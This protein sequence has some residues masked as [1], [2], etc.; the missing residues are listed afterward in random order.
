MNLHSY[1]QSG[2]VEAYAIGLITPA[3]K[4]EFEQLLNVYPEL[5]WEL[6]RVSHRIESVARKGAV[7]PPPGA[8]QKIAEAIEGLPVLR[9]TTQQK[10]TP[11]IGNGDRT[12]G[13]IEASVTSDHISV[14]KLMKPAFIIIFILSKIFL[15][16]LIFYMVKFYRA[17]SELQDVKHQIDL[18]KRPAGTNR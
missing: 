11:L 14:H 8:R 17:Q 5:Q 4:H 15:A 16:L 3:D 9:H 10:T 1:I 7:P 6:E 12:P 2:I 18:L 13:P